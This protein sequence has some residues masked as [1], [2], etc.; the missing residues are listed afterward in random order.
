MVYYVYN[1]ENG[2]HILLHHKEPDTKMCR[3][4]DPFLIHRKI[5]KRKTLKLTMVGQCDGMESPPPPLFCK[6]SKMQ[7]NY[8]YHFSKT[9]K[10]GWFTENLQIYSIRTELESADILSQKWKIRVQQ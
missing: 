2:F 8:F 3:W 6:R 7:F 4:W 5:Q 9:L 1:K 10:N